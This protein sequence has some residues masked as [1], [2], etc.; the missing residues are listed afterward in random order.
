MS[1]CSDFWKGS[2]KSY[3]GWLLPLLCVFARLRC[4]VDIVPIRSWRA[5]GPVGL[6]AGC[7]GDRA[8]LPP[9]VRSAGP[10]FRRKAWPRVSAACLPGRG[11]RPCRTFSASPTASLL[12]NHSAPSA[13]LIISNQPKTVLATSSSSSFLPLLRRFFDNIKG[14][15]H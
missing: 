15:V 8:A 14:F 3:L 7:C 2:K 11:I 13:T 10:A 6:L 9:I 12:L 5:G 4:R 1:S